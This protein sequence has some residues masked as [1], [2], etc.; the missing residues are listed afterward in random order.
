M[1]AEGA[2]YILTIPV[3]DILFSV[4]KQLFD[5]DEPLTQI[6]ELNESY[7]I[8]FVTPI[9]GKIVKLD[10]DTQRFKQWW[11]GLN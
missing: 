4:D 3:F 6:T 10:D 7:N 11:V 9:I 2:F 8:P 5:W 1:K